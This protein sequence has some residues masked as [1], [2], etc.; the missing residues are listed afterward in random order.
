M[1]LFPHCFKGKTT[2]YL[3]FGKAFKMRFSAI[4]LLLFL[5]VFI[6]QPKL[7]D[8]AV[9]DT[10]YIFLKDYGLNK[11]RKKDVVKYVNKALENLKGDQP[12]VLVFTPGEYH[13]Y[14]EDATVREYYESTSCAFLFENVHNLVINGQG[15]RLI[16]HGEMQPFTFDNCSNITLKD[17]S[18]DWEQPVTTQAEIMKVTNHFIELGIDEKQYPYALENEKLFFIDGNGERKEWS[19]TLELDRNERF[20][21]PQTGDESCLGKNWQHYTAEALMP[22]IFR[23]NNEFERQPEK[24]NYLVF[25][26]SS[27]THAGVF[28]TNSN[29]ITIKDFT[30]YHAAGPGILARSSGNLTFDGYRAVPNPAKN[31]Y[32]SGNDRG[33]QLINCSGK[34]SIRN[35]EFAGLLND[36]VKIQDKEDAQPVFK[37]SSPTS[38]AQKKQGPA[39][40]LIEKNAFKNGRS[41][42]LVVNTSGKMVVQ[43]N[44]FGSSGS[45]ILV[46][47]AA[48]DLLIEGNTFGE[49]CYT[50]SY[51]SS[52]AT[53]TISPEN[54]ESADKFFLRNIRISGNEFH[55]FDYPV[56]FARSVDGLT[57]EKNT[58]IRSFN[59]EPFHERHYTFTFDFCKNIKINENQFSGDLLDKKI[60]LKQT[61]DQEVNSDLGDQF[62]IDKF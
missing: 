40:F 29:N 30:L 1:Q 4:S 58:L 3:S 46:S 57:F 49:L 28:I 42:G 34:I 6:V 22:G 43:N 55:P 16:F 7:S 27:S 44:H 24:R 41:C 9:Q 31:R 2:K 10:T 45:A 54:R 25:K 15:S 60:L 32:F 56:L 20:I 50:G 18:I 47:G 8:A 26:Y 36:A 52:E 21:V 38:N 53:I 35:C 14:P 13:F 11:T 51:Q 62:L 17:L 23:L 61:A 48:N 59:F 12:K 39:E 19:S 5:S 33:L 37:G